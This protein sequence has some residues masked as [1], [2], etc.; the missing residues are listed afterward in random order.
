MLRNLQL[1]PPRMTTVIVIIIVMT[2][3]NIGLQQPKSATQ[4]TIFYLGHGVGK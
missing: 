1:A 4:K 3:A 2:S